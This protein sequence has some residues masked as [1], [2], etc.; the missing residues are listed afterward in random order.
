MK[1]LPNDPLMNNCIRID[2]FFI[3][4]ACFLN[5][6]HNLYPCVNTM[7]V[8]ILIL[9]RI[10]EYI[11]V[12]NSNKG[13]SATYITR[14]YGNYETL[15]GLFHDCIDTIR[16]STNWCHNND[17]KITYSLGDAIALKLIK[18][19]IKALTLMYKQK[20][21]HGA[22]PK[23]SLLKKFASSGKLM[24]SHTEYQNQ[25]ISYHV[26]MIDGD[27]AT[28]WFSASSFRDSVIS[29]NVIGKI[30]RFHHFQDM[31]YFYDKH[32]TK[33]DWGGVS[34]YDNPNGID[35]FKFSF[36]GEKPS[37]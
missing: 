18:S 28:L 13:N 22:K 31:A 14:L 9:K 26:Y 29:K 37:F 12:P 2:K 19:F 32:Y 1:K 10:D 15:D 25:D 16:N 5:F 33:Y 8:D 4:R 3:R 6:D 20:K 30:N 35:Q 34:S 7:P 27:C 11:D 36:P 21:F 23:K 17:V 24:I